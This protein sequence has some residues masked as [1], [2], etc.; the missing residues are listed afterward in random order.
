MSK[1]DIVQMT[2]RRKMLILELADG[3][4]PAF[5]Y[6]HI[7]EEQKYREEIYAWFISNEI[8]GRKFVEFWNERNNSKLQV[9]RDSLSKV[10][11]KRLSAMDIL[12]L[13][14]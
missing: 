8:K 6:I 7:L 13:R 9:V 2:D 1:I 12:G 5:R 11:K 3:Y 14:R 10:M 4:P